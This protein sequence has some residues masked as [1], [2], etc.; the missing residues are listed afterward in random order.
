MRNFVF[1]QEISDAP[2][3]FI[4]IDS[5]IKGNSKGLYANLTSDSNTASYDIANTS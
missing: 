3:S 4:S 1:I 2:E 5:S